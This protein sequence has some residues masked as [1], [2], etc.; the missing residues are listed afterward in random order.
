M[1]SSGIET[2][3]A[4]ASSSVAGTAASAG[5][6]PPRAGLC[7][8]ARSAEV[9]A[10]E[11]RPC[12]EA[13]PL[14]N[15]RDPLPILPGGLWSGHLG[16]PLRTYPARQSS[17]SQTTRRRTGSLHQTRR[18]PPGVCPSP[19]VA[20]RAEASPPFSLE[21]SRERSTRI[22]DVGASSALRPEPVESVSETQGLRV[23]LTGRAL[24]Q[25]PSEGRGAPCPDS[26]RR[27]APAPPRARV[28]RGPILS[29]ER[30]IVCCA[31]RLR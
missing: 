18:C 6:R 29:E 28:S 11:P 16:R 1:V 31:L 8:A 12:R 26:A 10:S 15:R 30:R 21:P 19:R 17:R 5:S 25:S 20:A 14:R 3:C 13:Q 23:F 22:S 4:S 27:A 24:S 9:S 2:F 7:P